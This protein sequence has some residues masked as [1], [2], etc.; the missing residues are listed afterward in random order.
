[1][2]ALISSLA[3]IAVRT[4]LIARGYDV[5]TLPP[6]PSLAA[7]V[8]AHPDLLVLALGGRLF[9]PAVYA[10]QDD[11]HAILD[12]LCRRSNLILSPLPAEEIWGNRY[13]NDI[14]L[15]ALSLSNRLYARTDAISPT[16][17]HATTTMG[18]TL[19]H[20]RQGYTRCSTAVVASN[21]IITA[22]RTIANAA[23]NEG[24][25]VLLISH[26]YI[27][28]PG[29]NYG[30]IGGATGYDKTAGTLFFCGTPHAHP[31]WT[32][33]RIQAFC[34]AHG[35]KTE[36]LSRDILTDVGGIHFFEDT[37]N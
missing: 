3:P 35:C 23:R 37:E 15:N 30:F 33:G 10:A 2:L 11:A 1:M 7:P 20:V 4:A 19:I 26:G 25:D 27:F 34:Y 17:R 24:A 12:E 18:M 14:K 22:D 31:D 8:C 29:Y 16:L 6:L 32:S 36:C 9:C 5:L 13:P 21:A 28:L